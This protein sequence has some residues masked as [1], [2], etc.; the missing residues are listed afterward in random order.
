MLLLDNNEPRKDVGYFAHHGWLA[1]GIRFF[2]SL[3]FPAKAAWVAVAMLAP[4]VILLTQQYS[5]ASDNIANTSLERQ[6]VAYIKAVTQLLHDLGSLRTAAML[7]EPELKQKQAALEKAFGNV[8]QMEKEFGPSFGGETKKTFAALSSRVNDVIQNPVGKDSD[9][10]YEEYIA[11]SNA[12]LELLGDMGDGSQLALDPELDTYHLMLIAVQ[13]GP[14]YEEYLTRLGD[15]AALTL[16]QGQGKPMPEP[17]LRAMYRNIT[18]ID[19]VDPIYEKSFHKGI[20]RFP[21]IASQMDMKGLD[22]AREAFMAALQKQIMVDAPAGDLA[23]LQALSSAAIDKQLTLNKQVV[24]RLDEQLAARIARIKMEMIENFGFSAAFLLVG[25]YLLLCFYKVTKGGLALISSHLQD[26]SQGDLRRR[27]IDPLGKDEPAMLILDMHKVYDSLQN[28]IRSVRHGA[29]ELASTSAEVSRASSDLSQRTEDA[30]S[31]LGI[32][33]GAVQQINEQINQSTMRTQ[34]AAVMAGGNAEVAEQG[35]KIINTVVETMHA[36]RTSSAR[37]GEI[38][39]TIDGIAFQTNILALNAAVEAAR[40]GESGRGFAVVASEVRSLAGRS[41]SAAREIKTLISDS[42]EKV[43]KGT[44]VVEE[45][46]RNISEIVANAKQIN[47]YLDAIAQSTNA[48]AMEVGQVVSAIGELDADIQQNAALVEETSASAK[49]LSDQ[50][51]KLTEE[52]AV[53]RVS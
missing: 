44:H 16:T 48:Q 19:Y 45:A 41:A 37:I 32:Q 18:R 6:G 30:A 31:N 27:P 15:L 26:L 10:T 53:F 14:Q 9:V 2:R 5:A 49:S 13:V 24:H 23:S 51:T 29:R 3:K 38:I 42:E 33:A 52:I 25:I 1:P 21:A 46:G 17:R 11:A 4:V 50:A 34:E 43:T 7:N 22:S 12:A 8:Q 40:A 39:G 47:L 28:L 36:I 20:D 35:G